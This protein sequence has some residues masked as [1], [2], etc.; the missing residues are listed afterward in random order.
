MKNTQRAS[1]RRLIGRQLTL[2]AIS[3]LA[4][5]VPNLT[6]AQPLQT[7]NMAV[8]AR[9]FQMVLYPIAQQK[10]YMKEEGL[11]QRVIF[12]APT[13]S[14]QAMLGGDVQF[15]G[16]GTSALVS[17][18]RGNTP[19]KVVAATNDRV[20]Q[21]LVTRPEITS[22]K[23][24]KGK[25]I[26]TTGVGAVA[27]FMLKQVLTKHG[28]DASK[29]VTF[30]DVGQGNQLAALLGGGF[31]A[32]VLSVEQRY[33]GLDKGMREMFFMGNEVKNS[34]GTLATTDKL[35]KENPKMVGGFVRATIKA[36]RYLRQDK[37]G[38]ISAMLK[39]SGVSRQQATRVYDDIIG[40]FTR[41]GVVD[42]ET[43]RN[44]LVIIRQVVNANETVPNNKAYDFSFALE[45]D[46][47]LNKMGWK[48]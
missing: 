13:T 1:T 34:W 16:A 21:W 19:L 11:D 45:A 44:D 17:I 28:L 47:Q 9:S 18:A 29:D 6:D 24:L 5:A 42:D 12:V 3:C 48:P 20:L 31:D 43:Q 27:T 7:V 30:L 46:Q 33:V 2:V 41:S 25:K 15:T 39:F 32:A 36:L 40:T 35:I 8:P 23:D 4:L 37:E 10:G 38:T 26:A 22:P 14:I